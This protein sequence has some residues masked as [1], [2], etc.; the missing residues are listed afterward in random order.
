MPAGVQ[1]LLAP[2]DT[3][4]AF[5][6]MQPLGADVA[7]AAMV[8]RHDAFIAVTDNACELWLLR[9][10]GPTYV[11][12]ARNGDVVDCLYNEFAKGAPA[13]GLDHNLTLTPTTVSYMNELARGGATYVFAWDSYKRAWYIKHVD[14][15]WVENGETGVNVYT[16][17]LDYPATLP[18]LT[19]DTFTPKAIRDAVRS[20]RSLVR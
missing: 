14:V 11:I 7:G 18:W 4:L 20:H 1:A 16:S 2:E 9:A 15:S 13:L 17:A 6:T 5:K 3:V 10:S 19:L 12:S 8:V